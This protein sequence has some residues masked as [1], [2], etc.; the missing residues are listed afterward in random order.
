MG[1]GEI[2]HMSESTKEKCKH[3]L[4]KCLKDDGRG[5]AEYLCKYCGTKLYVRYGKPTACG[6]VVNQHSPDINKGGLKP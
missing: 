2:N 4:G 6:M 3:A 5:Y 1:E